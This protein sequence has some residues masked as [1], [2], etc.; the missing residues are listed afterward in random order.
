VRITQFSD[1][2]LRVL[3]YLSRADEHRAPA[4][5]AEIASQ[6]DIP[7]NHLVKVVGRLVREGWVLATRG[8]NG[9]IRLGTDAKTLRIGAVLRKL[10][11]D[12]ELVDCEGRDCR[13]SRDCMLRGALKEGMR[14]FY[15][16]LDRYT[17]AE[18]TSGRAGERIV[19]MHRQ[20]LKEMP[21]A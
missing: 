10:E 21:L 2:G 11:G 13:L 15:D 3:I 8:R 5:I 20:F 1:I 12:E 19:R 17:L 14:A 7:V 4:T 18:L 6:F 16:S 9:G